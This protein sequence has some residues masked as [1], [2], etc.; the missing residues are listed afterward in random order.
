MPFLRRI[1]ELLTWM[2]SL[3]KD[4]HKP[5]ME[6]DMCVTTGS[7]EG[8]CKVPAPPV[9]VARH[10]AKTLCSNTFLLVYQLGL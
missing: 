3:Q 4:L 10:P 2:K 8:L 5:P 7:Q 1:P 9:T 6:M